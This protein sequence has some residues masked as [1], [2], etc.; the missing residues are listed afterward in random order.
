LT[1]RLFIS[2]SHRDDYYL[3]RLHVHLVQA[4]RDGVFQG[5]YDREITAGGHIDE[6]VARELELAD[7]FIALVSPDFLA[8]NYCYDRELARALRRREVGTIVVVPI[9]V[10][11]C[12]WQ[13]TP[14]G[15]LKAIPKDGKPIAEWTNEN[16]AFA[17]VVR[18]LR[19]LAAKYGSPLETKSAVPPA[20]HEIG[21]GVIKSRTPDNAS[22]ARGSRFRIKRTFTRL[23][24]EQFA[25]TAFEAIRRHFGASVAELNEVEGL[26][27]RLSVYSPS[28]FSCT[29]ENTGYGRSETIWVRRGG[30]LGDISIAYGRDPGDNSAHGSFAVQNDEYDLYLTAL[31]FR[32]GKDS[33]R[34][35]PESAARA[36]WDD[37]LSHVG[38]ESA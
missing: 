28:K 33:E 31:F 11:D 7:I 18:A 30:P 6:E 4:M 15:K 1:H 19:E 37:L 36:I 26:R 32:F 20:P 3:E 2:Y 17:A 27:G 9:I 34:L 24:K 21:V 16:T 10:H 35:S 13:S 12:D 5:W 14:L 29:V 38:I 22:G 8:S 25:E 23:D